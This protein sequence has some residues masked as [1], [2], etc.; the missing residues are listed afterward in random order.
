MWDTILEILEETLH[1]SL[2]TVPFLFVAYL[3]LEWIEHRAGEKLRHGLGHSGKYSIPIG[4]VIG[5]IPQCGF[6]VAAA[7]LYAGRLISVGTVI[8]VFVATS[9]EALPIM[10]ANPEGLN[11]ILP[12]LVMKFALAVIAGFFADFLIFRHGRTAQCSEDHCAHDEEREAATHSLCEHC[13]CEG[14]ILRSTLH[15]TLETFLFL[16]IVLLAINTATTLIG[17]EFLSRILLSD[18]VFSPFLTALIG[19]IPNCAPSVLISELYLGGTLSFGAALA[20]LSSGAG[21]GLAMLFRINRDRKQSLKILLYLY[22]FS[23]AAG[24]VVDVVMQL[25]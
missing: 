16:L 11:G 9:D 4:S 24:I 7:N 1:H 6:S 8:A 12:L 25:F 19:L 20:G 21:L 2:L 14:G 23:C 10:L 17:E 13:G 18:S 15:H 22:L 5:L 3:I